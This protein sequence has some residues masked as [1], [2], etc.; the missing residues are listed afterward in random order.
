MNGPKKAVDRKFL[1]PKAQKIIE[2]NTAEDLAAAN[3]TGVCNDLTIDSS[4]DF[5]KAACEELV[6]G[7]SKE[8]NCY[9]VLGRDRRG[10]RCSG[11][12]GLG[13]TQCGA[14]DIVVGRYPK[15]YQSGKSLW[16]NTDFRRDAARIYISQKTDIDAYLDIKGD[17]KS[18]ALSGIGIKADAVRIVGRRTI[19]LV[20]FTDPYDSRGPEN[21]KIQSVGGIHLIAGNQTLE[22]TDKNFLGAVQ[23]LVKGLNLTVLLGRIIDAMLDSSRLFD[24]YL[25]HALKVW[26]NIAQHEHHSPFSFQKTTLSPEAVKTLPIM[27]ITVIKEQKTEIQDFQQSLIKLKIN[28]GIGTKRLSAAE[29]DKIVSEGLWPHL[30]KW[31]LTN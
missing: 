18:T 6:K 20:T 26:E 31:N 16:T 29:Y 10:S 23:P 15:S 4:A 25:Q 7:S 5:I 28:W 3:L 21:G 17:P 30:S 24:R 14:I 22:R 11:Y 19:K 1:E 8:N 13:D 2:N 9:I 12:G 27:M